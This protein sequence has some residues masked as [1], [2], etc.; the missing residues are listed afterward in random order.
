MI[1]KR[2]QVDGVFPKLH[3]VEKRIEDGF[4]SHDVEPTIRMLLDEFSSMKNAFVKSMEIMRLWK[5]AALKHGCGG[6][7]YPV[8]EDWAKDSK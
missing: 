7:D 8:Y 1:D 4:Y 5:T 6:T 2:N 3:E